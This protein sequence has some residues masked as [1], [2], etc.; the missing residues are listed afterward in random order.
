MF[1]KLGL[2][3]ISL[4][5]INAAHGAT[6]EKQKEYDQYANEKESV[7]IDM[8]DRAMKTKGVDTAAL[9]KAQ[10]T[11]AEARTKQCIEHPDN[12]TGDATDK[13]NITLCMGAKAETRTDEI[14]AIMNAANGTEGV[15]PS[16]P[17]IGAKP[18]AVITEKALDEI[19]EVMYG[20]YAQYSNGIVAMKDI[21]AECWDTMRG[22]VRVAF[23]CAVAA[24]MGGSIEGNAGWHQRRFAAP[25]YQWPTAEK[26]IRDQFKSHGLK[27]T[28]A[29]AIIDFIDDNRL[30]PIYRALQNAGMR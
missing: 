30:G 12:Y 15:T 16:Q 21:E 5:A 18:E 11:W 20:N 14:V 6:P 9:L 26:R 29:Q 4:A 19:A 22:D 23:R 10:G 28:D 24:G 25:Y 3:A 27:D 1:R 8:F 7:L 2:I 17:A 13:G